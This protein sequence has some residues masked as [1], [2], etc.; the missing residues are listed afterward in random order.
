[1]FLIQL[2]FAYNPAFYFNLRKS[3]ENIYHSSTHVS[4]I[5]GNIVR[6]IIK[7]VRYYLLLASNRSFMTD[8][9]YWGIIQICRNLNEHCYYLISTTPVFWQIDA[10]C[11]SFQSLNMLSFHIIIRALKTNLLSLISFFSKYYFKTDT[12]CLLFLPSHA[13]TTL[14]FASNHFGILLWKIVRP[15]DHNEIKPPIGKIFRKCKLLCDVPKIIVVL[16]CKQ[17]YDNYNEASYV[18][19]NN[20][21]YNLETTF[22]KIVKFS[23]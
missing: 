12:V 3:Y 1:M 18:Q 17:V 9:M 13:F 10:N 22:Q 21:C 2:S 15:C 23:Q 4:A 19:R 7:F 6:T 20:K 5:T 11:S 8:S 16:N 14:E